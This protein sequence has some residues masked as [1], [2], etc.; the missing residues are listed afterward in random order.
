MALKN[1]YL[2]KKEHTDMKNNTGPS[3]SVV[4]NLSS[5]LE[6]TEA[7]SKAV[8]KTPN[9]VTLESMLEKIASEEYLHPESI[10]HMTI[11][12]L[13]LKNGFSLLGKSAPADPENLNP[14]A[15]R[16]FAKED[17]IRQMWQLEGYALRERLSARLQEAVKK[18]EDEGAKPY[19]E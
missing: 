19:G 12:V 16:K 3:L 9:R 15:G 4:S 8:A 17:A 1:S 11:C 18:A 7:Y 5:S 13:V 14:E 2:P 10:P 6:A